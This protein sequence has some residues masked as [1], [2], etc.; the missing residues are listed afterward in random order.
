MGKRFVPT[1]GERQQPSDGVN[2]VRH[3]Y[4]DPQSLIRDSLS[5]G[6]WTV[7]EGIVNAV[8]PSLN[9]YTVTLDDG[10][11]VRAA[12][13]CGQTSVWGAKATQAYSVG[14]RVICVFNEKTDT[15]AIV[16]QLD[17]FEDDELVSLQP[18]SYLGSWVGCL[19]ETGEYLI[20]W[21]AI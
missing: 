1:T 5:A 3:N 4:G 18:V 17:N 20:R 7:H 9:F 12:M 15:T 14:S 10:K 11:D 8:F 19:W 21:V 16:S 6:S 13:A 2:L